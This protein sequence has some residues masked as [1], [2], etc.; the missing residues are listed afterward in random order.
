M[1]R[2][3]FR[4]PEVVEAFAGIEVCKLDVDLAANREVGARHRRTVSL[5][6]FVALA[7]DGREVHQWS[8]AL[9]PADLL[10]ELATAA[11]A[12]AP[13]PA[14]ADPVALGEFACARCDREALAPQ[15][16]ALARRGAPGDAEQIERL[17]W[18][19]CTTSFDQQRWPELALATQDY[20]ARC[21]EGA[22][23]D[24]AMVMQGRAT[25]AV[26]GV[27]TEALRAHIDALLADGAVPF[28]GSS[29][30]DRAKRFAGVQDEAAERALRAAAS[31]WVE[32]V[33]AAMQR[34]ARLGPP[35]VPALRRALL[36]GEGETMRHAATTLGW[37]RLP[38]NVGFLRAQLERANT[39]APRRAEV[40]RALAMHKDP[41]CLPLFVAIAR[42]DEPP[43][44]RTEAVEGIRDLCH[45]G[46]GTT[47]PA[48]AG[49]LDAALAHRDLR[50]RQWTLQAMFEVKA[51]LALGNLL[52]ALDDR[53][54]LFA[55]FR[56]CG[57][58]MWILGQQ[59]G[60]LVQVDGEPAGTCTPA[61]AAFLERWY[62]ANRHRLVWD[63]DACHWAVRDGAAVQGK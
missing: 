21:P 42:G 10:R 61:I 17:L 27:L 49:A 39:P 26:D 36:E 6:T 56:I 50:L 18:L 58:A 30:L 14:G 7:A 4:A 45:L 16:A 25:F 33:N 51:P 3:T 38:E 13:P 55:E 47:D 19:L 43:R 59:L 32:R 31:A 24:E 5:P 1:E 48:V 11:A 52:E 15:L 8:G 60:S 41:A 53:R 62:S 2:V 40:V 57:N 12:A 9:P 63:A 35:A 44:V 22:H 34:L 29:L 28:P 37:M 23:R 54:T 46:D 20:L